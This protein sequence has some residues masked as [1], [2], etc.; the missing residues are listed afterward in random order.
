MAC[1]TVGSSICC[2]SGSTSDLYLE[3]ASFLISSGMSGILMEDFG[4]FPQ[5]LYAEARIIL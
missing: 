3:S 4:C 5:S 2:S 1:V